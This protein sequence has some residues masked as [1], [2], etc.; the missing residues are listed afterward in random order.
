VVFRVD[1]ISRAVPPE[2]LSV[3]VALVDP[4][5]LTKVV[6]PK[7]EMLELLEGDRVESVQFHVVPDGKI[8]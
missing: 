2:I 8:T 4:V 5:E 1:F 7:I 6:V 3:K